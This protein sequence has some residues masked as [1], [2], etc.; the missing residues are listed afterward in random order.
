MEIKDEIEAEE[1]ERTRKELDA[2]RLEWSQ[3]EGIN[4]DVKAASE[5]NNTNRAPIGA[6]ADKKAQTDD[7]GQPDEIKSIMSIDGAWDQAQSNDI[8]SLWW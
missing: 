7:R 6:E 8:L 1:L 3:K 5:G 2:M 4:T